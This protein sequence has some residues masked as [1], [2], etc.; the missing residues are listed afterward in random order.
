[1]GIDPHGLH[2]QTLTSQCRTGLGYPGPFSVVPL[3]LL[4]MPVDT[5]QNDH[6]SDAYGTNSILPAFR[7][8]RLQ[9]NRALRVLLDIQSG[10]CARMMLLMNVSHRCSIHERNH[11]DVSSGHQDICSQRVAF[12]RVLRRRGT[13]LAQHHRR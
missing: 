12:V 8:S 11:Q 10:I 13:G 7:R 3:P 2:A 6:S 5:D 9:P 1:M 4:A